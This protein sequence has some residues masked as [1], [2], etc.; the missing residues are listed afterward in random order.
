MSHVTSI[1]QRKPTFF[2]E[3][4]YMEHP[5]S[6]LNPRILVVDDDDDIR[7][8]LK[9]LLQKEGYEIHLATTGKEAME[10]L[11]RQALDAVVL[12]ICLPD[13]DGLYI[14]ESITQTSPGL[15]VII[16]SGLS[17]LHQVTGPLD[18]QGAF[19]H[20]HKPINRSE[21][22]TTVRQAVKAYG[23]V[24]QMKRTQRALMDSELRFQSI[25]Q[26]A[27][28]AIVLADEQG[29]ITGWNHAAESMFGYSAEEIFGQPLTLL[30]P[31]RYRDAHIQGMKRVSQGGEARVIGKTVQLHGLRKGGVEFP[32][33]LSLNAWATGTQPSYSG[34]IRDLSARKATISSHVHLA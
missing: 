6:Q 19:A 17:T 8:T 30:M 2:P 20:L 34:F 3:G 7:L 33:E 26:T 27:T 1:Q 9:D 11:K 15:P 5:S 18:K 21:I 25:F 29:R 23:L 28:D 4:R 24:Q 22:K 13:L 32:I 14:L 16:L 10:Q 12:D 31:V